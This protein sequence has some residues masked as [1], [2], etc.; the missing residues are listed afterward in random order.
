MV[1]SQLAREWHRGGRCASR[2]DG[3]IRGVWRGERRPAGRFRCGSRAA[4]G[5]GVSHRPSA[6]PGA[7]DGVTGSVNDV[8][9]LERARTTV[10][11]RRR[12][13]VPSGQQPAVPD[14]PDAGAHDP[15]AHA[16]QCENTRGPVHLGT[17]CEARALGR[18]L[19]HEGRSPCGGGHREGVLHLAIRGVHHRDVQPP[20]LRPAA[21]RRDRRL[22]PVLRRRARRAGEDGARVR[23][24]AGAKRSAH[25]AL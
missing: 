7:L 13:R 24:T 17:E 11:A 4:G 25:A 21:R 9:R 19:A 8:H 15:R 10:L 5:P 16:W 6:A 12:L 2:D 1:S 22:R 23:P 3:S 14:R 20:A 18:A